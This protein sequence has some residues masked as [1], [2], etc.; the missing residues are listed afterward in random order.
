M[1]DLTL[2]KF[3]EEEFFQFLEKINSSGSKY[4]L[5]YDGQTGDRKYESYIP[6]ELYKRTVQIK[7]N[8]SGFTKLNNT[9]GVSINSDTYETIYYNFVE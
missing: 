7:V 8:Q 2:A 9:S 5:T 3:K 6:P 4:I 1:Y